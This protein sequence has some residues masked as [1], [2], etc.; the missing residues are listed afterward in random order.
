MIYTHSL[1]PTHV[2]E[3]GVSIGVGYGATLHRARWY[4]RQ[5]ILPHENLMFPDRVGYVRIPTTVIP[6]VVYIDDSIGGPVS[7]GPPATEI[8]IRL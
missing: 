1:N 4:G 6:A 7:L 5:T 8:P 3:G 2:S